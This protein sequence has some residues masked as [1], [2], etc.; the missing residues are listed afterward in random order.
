MTLHNMG[1]DV[2]LVGRTMHSSLPLE[3]RVYTTSRMNLFLKKEFAF[4]FF[5]LR[6]FFF[7]L[8]NKAD[9]YVSNDLDTLWPNYLIS[10]WRKK[11][12]C[13]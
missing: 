4:T 10:K 3:S 13:V 2:H 5:Q 6:L 12:T 11:N 1:F 8:K 7:L 9:I